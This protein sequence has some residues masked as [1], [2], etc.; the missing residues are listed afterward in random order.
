MHACM[1]IYYM[2]ILYSLYVYK[3]HVYIYRKHAKLLYI[4]VCKLLVG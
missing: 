1:H 2:Y 3:K 4:R